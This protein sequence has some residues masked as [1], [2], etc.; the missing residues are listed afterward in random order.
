M[1]R[2]PRFGEPWAVTF[3]VP[4]GLW[5]LLL[6][7][8]AL[9]LEWIRRRARRITVPSL[10]LWEEVA[11]QAGPPPP[12]RL[13][14]LPFVAVATAFL[15]AGAGTALPL[16]RTG[17]ASRHSVGIVLDNSAASA[18]L[19][20]G[21]GTRWEAE[22]RE[23]RR[24]LDMLDEG[25]DLV[26]EVVPGGGR[27]TGKRE[28]LRLVSSCSPSDRPAPA[29][30][31]AVRAAGEGDDRPRTL[32][33]VSPAPVDLPAGWLAWHPVGESEN[34]GIVGLAAGEPDPRGRADLLVRV[35]WAG[36]P[37]SLSVDASADGREVARIPVETE[38]P[39]G[40]RTLVLPGAVP[41]DAALVTCRVS[42]GGS[43]AL[44]DEAA[45]VATRRPLAG[46]LG[47]DTLPLRIA[48]TVAGA[49]VV[50]LAGT[51]EAS[52]VEILV[53][54]GGAVPP[55]P[56]AREG[57][58]PRAVFAVGCEGGAGPFVPGPE[59]PDATYPPAAHDALLA[60]VPAVALA[61]S[62]SRPVRL[63]R[64]QEAV[65]G[66]PGRAAVAS[67][68]EGGRRWLYVGV[69]PDRATTSWVGE[70]AFPIFW[71]NAV[72][73]GTADGSAGGWGT[74]SLLDEGSTRAA[75]GSA[76]RSGSVDAPAVLAQARVREPL[77]RRLDRLCAA[78][79]L[80]GL[81]A[82]ALLRD[83]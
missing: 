69:T 41:P 14:D 61:A 27:V 74:D 24:L 63:R 70:A 44:D 54:C 35:A 45:L 49:R 12:P 4:A 7:V 48:L 68:V 53:V 5:F 52:A 13:L 75:A 77:H 65:Y 57:R 10:V 1:D 55:L 62:R 23:V 67:A 9:A 66:D 64:G 83:R 34:A 60:D 21:G 78:L 8:P 56:V 3:S 28:A 19:L 58:G 51:A 71:R 50:P 42:P 37:A 32:W 73:W 36:G 81:L 47:A 76:D 29:P 72:R 17:E 82:W 40:A 38:S 11:R 43:L 15:A 2:R 79:A 18:A 20:P 26:L 80:A 22:V 16:L 46:V 39:A 25:D 30:P 31:R 59:V 6:A 33:R